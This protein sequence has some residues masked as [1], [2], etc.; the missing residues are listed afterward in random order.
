MRVIGLQIAIGRSSLDLDRGM[1][2]TEAAFELVRQIA[3]KRVPGAPAGTTRCAVS[4][5]S[6]VLIPQMWRSCTAL[7]PSCPARKPRT[8]P[9]SICR[10]TASAKAL[11]WLE[12]A[13]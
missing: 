4:A 5:H 6:V 3:Q 13:W 10:G 9:S 11:P 7:T 8:A 12:G 2:N 1:M